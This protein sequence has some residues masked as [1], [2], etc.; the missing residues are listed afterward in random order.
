MG[1]RADFGFLADDAI[2]GAH[3]Q[4]QMASRA[5]SHVAQPCGA[6]DSHALADAAR[7]ENL[8]VGTDHAIGRDFRLFGNIGG[9]GIDNRHAGPHQLSINRCTN[10]RF[11]ICQLLARVDSGEFRRV[12]SN[13]RFDFLIARTRNRDDIGQVVLI[14]RIGGLQF[15]QRRTKQIAIDQVTAGVDFLDGAL[16]WMTRR[17]TRRFSRR[18]H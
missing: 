14:L 2:F 12:V 16:G 8:D 13:P 10:F 18:C 6:V 9:R 4:L 17:G 1:E 15:R 7:A 5:N 3:A 11:H